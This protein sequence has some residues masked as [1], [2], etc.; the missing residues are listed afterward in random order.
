MPWSGGVYTRGYPSWTND[1]NANLPISATKF[2][3]EDNDFAS[4]LNN[5]LTI[6]GLNKP[7]TTLTWAQVLSVLSLA[8]TGNGIPQNGIYLPL[9]STLGFS[10]ASTQR[11]NINSVG[12]WTVNAPTSGIAF[13][14]TG[15][16]SQAIA[17]LTSGSAFN[18]SISDFIINRNGSTA[19]VIS[20]GPSVEVFDS[21][22]TTGSTLQH[23]G[24]QTELWQFNSGWVQQWR[25][26][27]AGILQARDQAGTMQDLGWRDLSVNVQNANYAPALSDRGKLIINTSGGPFTYTI[28]ANASV[29]FPVGTVLTFMTVSGNSLS[30]AITT[31]QMVLAGTGGTVGTRT[32]AN[33]GIATAVKSQA[34][35]WII[36]GTGLT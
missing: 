6:D 30:I 22:A 25:T 15:F 3:T 36:S 34:T 11:G 31:D 17:Q 7:N 1:A 12:N 16:A 35:Q 32:L 2:D 24:G 20:Q 29:A 23:S 4:G 5:C 28:P 14:V 10:T 26:T 9:A 27:S 21:G 13:G 8:V 18:V 19:N 33:S